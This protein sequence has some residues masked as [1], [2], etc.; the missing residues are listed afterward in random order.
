MRTRLTETL[1]TLPHQVP[2]E[3]RATTSIAI[4]QA[5]EKRTFLNVW[6]F[7][8]TRLQGEPAKVELQATFPASEALA[9]QL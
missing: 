9:L 5:V 8:F 4:L 7:A 6:S 3:R 2:L 1:S